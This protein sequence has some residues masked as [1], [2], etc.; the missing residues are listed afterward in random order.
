MKTIIACLTAL[1]LYSILFALEALLSF[2]PLLTPENMLGEMLKVDPED[3][4]PE[5]LPTKAW[6]WQ[7][8]DYLI[9]EFHPEIFLYMGFSTRQ[10]KY[11]EFE[12]QKPFADF[13]KNSAT[14]YVKVAI[15]I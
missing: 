13:T 1:L 12:D 5:S 7:D 15:T 9:Y 10:T 6:I 14:A 4:T 3:A 2:A 8:E 11:S